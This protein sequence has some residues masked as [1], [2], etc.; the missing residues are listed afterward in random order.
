MW[1]SLHVRCGLNFELGTCNV[2]KCIFIFFNINKVTLQSR[3]YA[4]KLCCCAYYVTHKQLVWITYNI[5]Y[6][7]S[8]SRIIPCLHFTSLE[9]YYIILPLMSTPIPQNRNTSP[10]NQTQLITWE[11]Y[12]QHNHH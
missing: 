12:H 6:L 5:K 8:N 9:Q 4:I 11:E 7:I 3:T 2:I 1:Q 10:K